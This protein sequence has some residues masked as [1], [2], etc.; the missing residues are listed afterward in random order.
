VPEHTVD[1][2]CSRD[3]GPPDEPSPAIAAGWLRAGLFLVAYPFFAVFQ[4]L[5]VLIMS[6][7]EL[8]SIEAFSE[9]FDRA[10]MIPVQVWIL[11]SS[12]FFVWLFR[13]VV[14]RRSLLSLGFSFGRRG[15]TDLVAGF[16]WGAG[17]T[18]VIFLILYA[19]GFADIVAVGFP[20]IPLATVVVNISMAAA[21]EEIIMRGYLLNNLMQSINKYLALALISVLFS[22]GHGLNPN[23]SIIGLVN[24]ILA[25]FFLG[26]SYVHRKNLWFPIGLHIGWNFFQGA[27]LGSPISGIGIESILRVEF[28]GQESISGGKFG[29]EGSLVA[30]GVAL[31][32]TIILHLRYRQK[33][34]AGGLSPMAKRPQM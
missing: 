8:N 6:G 16:L 2:T 34:P 21:V 1:N 9:T 11:A 24:I 17:M 30:T 12:V 26:I 31:A 22:I 18:V 23:F 28:S 25:G 4:G 29:F 10:S 19:A 20:L 14:D 3:I 32:A 33:E 15:R 13:K 5:V 7:F 27:V